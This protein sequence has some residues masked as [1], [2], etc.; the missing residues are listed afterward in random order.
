MAGPT[1]LI[2]LNLGSQ[3]IALAEF[4]VAHGGL[5]LVNYRLRETPLDPETGQRRDAHLA[6]HDTA[7]VLGEMLHDMQIPRRAVNYALPAPSV[8]ARFV[9]MPPNGQDKLD[10]MIWFV[11][12][13]NGPIPLAVVVWHCEPVA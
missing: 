12:Q 9:T 8:F 5:V 4:R 11:A 10:K 3:A 7:A 1:R 2:T 13:Q 6:L